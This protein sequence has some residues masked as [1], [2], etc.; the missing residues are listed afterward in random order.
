MTLSVS[1]VVTGQQATLG[2]EATRSHSRN[3]LQLSSASQS[4]QE[5]CQAEGWKSEVQQVRSCLLITKW[6]LHLLSLNW[7]L[8]QKCARLLSLIDICSGSKAY[9]QYSCW[10]VSFTMEEGIF[11]GG[12]LW[13]CASYSISSKLSAMW[14][15]RS[16]RAF[17]VWGWVNFV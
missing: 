3:L 1:G 13:V 8:I 17:K 12:W 6:A 4:A 9:S 14:A 2:E 7:T 10:D 15:T 11:S 5:S 16:Y